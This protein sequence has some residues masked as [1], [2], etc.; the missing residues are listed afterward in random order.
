[1]K[2][3]VE[4]SG[5]PKVNRLILLRHGESCWNKKNIFTG[6]V[7]IS[8]SRKGIEESLKAGNKIATLPIDL[9]FTSALIRSQMTALL[10]MGVHLDERSPC[11]LNT[12]PSCK[13]ERLFSEQLHDNCIPLYTAW[14]LN[15]RCY[16]QLQGMN[17]EKAQQHYGTEQIQAWR[18]G[19]DA[20]PPEGESLKE[21]TE[22]VVPYLKEQIFPHFFKGKNILICA[23]GN[24]LRPIIMHLE[25]LS[26][27]EVVR[28]EIGTAI[29]YIY[30]MKEGK[31]YRQYG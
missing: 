10:A 17:K 18:R 22:R 4:T 5:D 27:E 3:A 13:E 24:S 12:D 19:Y 14:Q 20:I 15:E 6:W 7:N 9:I 28:L 25:S 26:K 31:W 29:P 8:L 1:M 2:E 21:T 11:L 23:H 30:A 16:G